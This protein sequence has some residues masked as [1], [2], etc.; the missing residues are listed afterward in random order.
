M[1]GRVLYRLA[2]PGEVLPAGGQ[3]LTIVDLSD[4]YMTVFLPARDAGRV[5]IGA[6]APHRARRR[7]GAPIP[8]RLSFVAPVAQ[9][10]PKEVETRS[11]REKL[12]FR[13]K[14]RVESRRRWRAAWRASRRGCRVRRTF[15]STRAAAGRIASRC[16]AGDEHARPHRRA[17]RDGH[18]TATVTR[19]RLDRRRPR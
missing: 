6:E 1:T 10:T 14:V 11:E 16:S 8:A 18:A 3:L 5:P 12:T 7:A 13:A 4:V 19:R 9:F 2:E 17:T 15:A